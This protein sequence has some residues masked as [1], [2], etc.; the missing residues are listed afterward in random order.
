M[1]LFY[2]LLLIPELEPYLINRMASML[3]LLLKKR[4]LL[5]PKD[6]ILEW[7]PLYNLYHRLFYGPYEALGMVKYPE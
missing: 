3:N 5:E 6:L 2:D 1:K 4:Q 7:Q